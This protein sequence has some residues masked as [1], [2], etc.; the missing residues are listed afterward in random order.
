MSIPWSFL[1]ESHNTMVNQKRHNLIQSGKLCLLTPGVCETKLD[2]NNATSPEQPPYLNMYTQEAHA[3]CKDA[4][5]FFTS[6][7]YNVQ[8]AFS[9]D[10]RMTC[11]LIFDNKK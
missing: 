11:S 7:N 5:E 4:H 8:Y 1:Y 6:L 3:I 2:L 10:D 9:N